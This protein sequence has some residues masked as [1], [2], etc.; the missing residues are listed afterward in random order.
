MSFRNLLNV[1]PRDT[2]RVIFTSSAGVERQGAFPYL[3]LNAFGSPLLGPFHQS[4]VF[5][6][7]DAGARVLQLLG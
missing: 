1:M 2:K 7:R 3:I 5:K 4:A 6:S